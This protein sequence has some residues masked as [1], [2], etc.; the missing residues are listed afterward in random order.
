METRKLKKKLEMLNSG[1]SGGAVPGKRL[2]SASTS[3]PGALE[4]S[5]NKPV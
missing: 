2:R 1:V 4:D 3:G 5:H